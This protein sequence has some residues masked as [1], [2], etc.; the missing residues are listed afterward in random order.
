METWESLFERSEAYDTSLDDVRA[1]LR[2][3]RADE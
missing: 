2:E 1:A 3:R